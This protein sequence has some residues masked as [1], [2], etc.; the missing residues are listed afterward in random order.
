MLCHPK[1][2]FRKL[3]PLQLAIQGPGPLQSYGSTSFNTRIAVLFC[4]QKWRG[5]SMEESE[6]EV[7]AGQA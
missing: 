1:W 5:E 6:R 3:V 2:M 7:P 4:I